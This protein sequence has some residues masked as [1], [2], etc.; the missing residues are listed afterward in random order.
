MNPAK[1]EGGN[2]TLLAEI[3]PKKK[4]KNG[5]EKKAKGTKKLKI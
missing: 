4:K 2:L 5:K 1:G 3:N